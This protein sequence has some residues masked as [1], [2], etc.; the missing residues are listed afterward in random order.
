MQ[1][2]YEWLEKTVRSLVSRTFSRQTSSEAS[3]P[4]EYQSDQS[5]IFPL[6]RHEGMESILAYRKGKPITV[7][8][9]LGEVSVVA[10]TLPTRKYVLNLCS[11]RYRFTVVLAAALLRRQ[12]T[13]LPPNDTPELLKFLSAQYSDLYC[14]RDASDPVS[15]FIPSVPYPDDAVETRDFMEIPYFPVQQ[16]AAIVFTSGSTGRPL[17]QVKTW[18]SIVRSARVAGIRLGVFSHPGATL[19]GTVPSQHMYGLESTVLLAL[20]HGLTLYSGRLFYPKDIVTALSVVPKPRVLVSTPVHIRA[21]LDDETELPPVDLAICATAPLSPHLAA[22]AESRLGAPLYEIY[23]CTEVGQMATRR[24]VKTEE[25]SCFDGISLRQDK[26]GTWAQIV[27]TGGDVL[28]ND[29]IELRDPGHF[30]LHGRTGDLVN[31]AGKRT[32]LAHLNYHL[33]SIEGVRDGIFVMPDESGQATV[34]LMAFVVAPA[35]TQET[36]MDSLRK[37]IDPVFL[38]RP[39]CLVESLPRN[40]TGKLSHD[41]VN[42]LLTEFAER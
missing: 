16:V 39:L 13:L 31:I 4:G 24:T 18:G 19:L 41:A 28:L 32:S 30:L 37:R 17:P 3:F 34:R 29:V 10:S 33:N 14:L 6:L 15:P 38:P 20:Q 25:W 21:L 2:T 23:G 9:F 12:I 5:E 1:W 36:I 8:Q 22:A 27:H 7:A 42:H 26:K 35:L 11:D 40:A